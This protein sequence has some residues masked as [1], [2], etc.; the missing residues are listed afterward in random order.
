MMGRDTFAVTCFR[1]QVA[2]G[3]LTGDFAG[4]GAQ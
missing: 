1:A 2:T 3:E 4:R